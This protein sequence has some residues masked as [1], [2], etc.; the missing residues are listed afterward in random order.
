MTGIRRPPS[1]YPEQG[2]KLSADVCGNRLGHLFF[3]PPGWTTWPLPSISLRIARSEW[4]TL[5][6]LYGIV[7]SVGGLAYLGYLH[8]SSDLLYNQLGPTTANILV[9]LF[10]SVLENIPVMYGVLGMMPEMSLDQ[11]LL[12]TFTVGVGGS[13]LSIGSAAG[14]TGMEAL[15]LLLS[16]GYSCGLRLWCR[17]PFVT[18]LWSLVA[19]RPR[20]S[21]TPNKNNIY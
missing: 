18:A 19:A 9:G 12:A 20:S 2:V 16:P 11:W 21:E 15:H 4:D 7:L 1:L 14:G 6:F 17:R 3:L 5:F 8:L 13:L 10:S